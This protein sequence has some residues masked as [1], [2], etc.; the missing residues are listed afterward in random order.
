MKIE[1]S[2][3]PESYRYNSFDIGVVDDCALFNNY[4]WLFSRLVYV[5][6]SNVS[7]RL[8]LNV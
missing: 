3:L 2:L 8:R 6:V 7:G 5:L 1:F 4:L